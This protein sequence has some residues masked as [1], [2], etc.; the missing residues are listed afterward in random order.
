MKSSM[1]KYTRLRF[2]TILALVVAACAIAVAENG[3]EEP[4][5]PP[6]SESSPKKEVLTTL[7]QRM[8]ARI[9]IDVSDLPID[10][11]IR[12]LAEQA[13]VD[14]IQSPKVIGNVT[15]TLTDVPLEEALKNILRA[16]G[17]DYVTDKNMIR[18]VPAEDIIQ[19][20]ERLASKIYRITYADV[21]E[22]E[23]ALQKFVSKRGTVSLNKGTSHV[24]VTDTESNI[25][26]IDKFVDEIDQI[27]PQVLIEVRI[28]DVT[29][30]DTLDIGVQWNAGR[31]T[32][33]SAGALG[34]NP[35]DHT[36]PFMSGTFR[37][38]TGKTADTTIGTLRFGWLD[39]AIDI[40]AEISA[41]QED[42]NAKLLANPRILVL[43]NEKALFDI[44]TEHPYVERTI[45]GELITE[46]IKYK[47]VG[48]TLQVTPHITRDDMVRLHIIPEFGVKVRDVAL[49]S[50]D[51]PVIDTR[52]IDTITLVKDGQTVVL[53]GLR[54]KEVSQQINKVPLLGDIPLL[55]AL[56]RFK[57][58]DTTNS[59]IIVF[60]TPR[61]I[62]RPVLSEDEQQ[63]YKATE[64]SGPKPV[65]TGAEA[66]ASKK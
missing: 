6:A 28:Y 1:T 49:I 61:I 4:E 45:S 56:F 2:L 51:V 5:K 35:S 64:F 41:Q 59:E 17:F 15:A 9:T 31:V 66:K 19:A 22:V 26:A 18:I 7:E 47:L 24:I 14:L 25:K 8:Q 33:Y 21:T 3:N 60:I 46:T 58:E 40:D 29:S 63:A 27:T 44:V 39:S 53:G 52:K 12:Q 54:K 30:Q 43:D 65:I 50:G 57:G 62:K 32:D 48:T 42:I 11:V 37:G 10:T 23:R 16:H 36:F 38:P 13:D 34:N 20:E 55:G